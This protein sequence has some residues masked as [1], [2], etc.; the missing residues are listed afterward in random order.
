MNVYLSLIDIWE[1][2]ENQGSQTYYTVPGSSKVQEQCSMFE[3]P[4][5]L[6]FP[7]YL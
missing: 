2:L 7:I 5:F 3:I 6:K 1:I 4:D